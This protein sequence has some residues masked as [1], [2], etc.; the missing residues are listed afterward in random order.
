MDIEVM[1]ASGLRVLFVGVVMSCFAFSGLWARID[2]FGQVDRAQ[3]S[4][5]IVLLG[6]MVYP[7]GRVGPSL[8][9]RAFHAAALYHRGLAPRVLCTGGIGSYPP[10][11]A[12]VACS[13]VV[14]LGVPASAIILEDQARNTEQNAAYTARLMRESRWQSAI[15]VSDGFH[16]YRAT[17]MFE[18]Q[19]IIT[20]PSPAEAT[21]GPMNVVERIV[22][23]LREAVGVMWYGLRWALG[24]SD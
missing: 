22:R 11:E 16:L 12:I 5:V 15:V 13:R 9:R 1:Q 14:E 24:Q 3:P 6:S 21:T 17:T 20:Y 2:Q 18:Q 10:S 8:E 7:G 23:E 4:D 19:R